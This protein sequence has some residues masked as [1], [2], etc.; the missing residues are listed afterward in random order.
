MALENQPWVEL[1][2]L[3]TNRHVRIFHLSASFLVLM[4]EG[5]SALF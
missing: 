3:G 4:L 2:P 5:S 1:G